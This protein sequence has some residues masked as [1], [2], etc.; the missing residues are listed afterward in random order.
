MPVMKTAIK[1]IYLILGLVAVV[2]LLGTGQSLASYYTFPSALTICDELVPLWDHRIWERMDRE[3]MLN[4]YDRGQ[5]YLWLKRSTRYFPHIEARLKEKGMPDDLKYLMVAESSLRPQALSNKGA[6]GFWQFIEKTG[7]RFN[8][9]KKP[10]IDE[11]LDLT[12]STDAAISYLKLLYDQ[13]GKW[14]LA[15]AAYNCGEERV[16]EEISQQGENDYYR[17]ALPQETERYIF[18]ILAAKV[19]LS[20]PKRYGFDLPEQESYSIIETHLVVLQLPYPVALRDIAKACGSFFKE[21][22]E[23]NPEI[24]GHTLPAGVHQIKIPAGKKILLEK[25]YKDFIKTTP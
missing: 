22:K 15:M 24:Q 21:L 1:K 8:L 19:I 7:K 18:R 5:I 25:Q 16:K 13:F 4:V 14:T 23:L 3:F 12:K 6:A 10:H 17:L 11:R 9:Q 2:P 20:D